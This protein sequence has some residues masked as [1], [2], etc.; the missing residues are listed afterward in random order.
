[1]LFFVP[2]SVVFGGD[3]AGAGGRLLYLQYSNGVQRSHDIY[4]M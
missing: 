4:S 1:M 2:A 3:G